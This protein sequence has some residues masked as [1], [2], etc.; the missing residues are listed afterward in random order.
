MPDQATSRPHSIQCIANRSAGLSYLCDCFAAHYPVD[1]PL[2][3]EQGIYPL[4]GPVNVENIPPE[5]D[6]AFLTNLGMTSDP[7][8]DINGDGRAALSVI[9]SNPGRLMYVVS[10]GAK[11][12]SKL[13]HALRAENIGQS[14]LAFNMA[15]VSSL[16][17][18]FRFRSTRSPEKAHSL[19][20]A[21]PWVTNDALG[22]PGNGNGNGVGTY[23]YEQGA[24][25]I[26]TNDVSHATFNF[27]Q[28]FNEKF[29]QQPR[30]PTNKEFE[31]E[32]NDNFGISWGIMIEKLNSRNSIKFWCKPISGRTCDKCKVEWDRKDW[33]EQWRIYEG[34][35]AGIYEG[36]EVIE[37]PTADISWTYR[38]EPLA[39]HSQYTYIPSLPCSVLEFTFHPEQTDSEF[40]I[41]CNYHQLVISAHAKN[42][43][44]SPALRSQYL[45]F[46]R[47]ADNMKLDR[48]TAKDLYNWIA[49]P[50]L[51]KFG[52]V[53][54][55][56]GGLIL[57]DFLFPKVLRYDIRGE[58]ETLVT[59]TSEETN[60][61]PSIFGID[62][63]EDICMAWP[64]YGPKDIHL[65]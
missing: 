34:M 13:H 49:E 9:A 28:Q 54:E 14:A 25:A 55:V 26:P 64:Q 38:P 53:L 41:I 30:L 51:H 59:I 61:V 46:L 16:L 37:A 50:L 5:S 8:N 10:K 15:M 63:S 43:S 32:D 39:S 20:A 27:D 35:E 12:D 65:P 18:G 2:S 7:S 58:G 19:K 52:H 40:V 56:K 1:V 45:F 33:I 23:N 17:G 21:V 48:H 31:R 57:H 4:A 6:Q 24:Y 29:N 47:V 22:R 36:L 3:L 11:K 42:F 62:L 44:Q 60:E